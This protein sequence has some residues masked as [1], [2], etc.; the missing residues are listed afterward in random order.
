MNWALVLSV[1]LPRPPPQYL[2]KIFSSPLVI[3]KYLLRFF[4]IDVSQSLLILNNANLE[5]ACDIASKMNPFA[6]C[7]L[8]TALHFPPGETALE[9]GLLCSI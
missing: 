1:F 4:V 5:S 3:S 6:G 8:T 2:T 7:I 9:T